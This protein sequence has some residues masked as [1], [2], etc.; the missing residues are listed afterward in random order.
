MKIRDIGST[1]QK[2]LPGDRVRDIM[3]LHP[4]CSSP[5]ATIHDIARKMAE[6]N[7]GEIPI[8]EGDRLVGVVT[9]RDIT[10]RAVSAG[11]H[12]DMTP[13]KEV[14]TSRP[15]VI[16]PEETIE[17]A[18]EM[19]EAFQV[20]RLPVVDQN[21][22]LVGIVSMTDISQ[23]LPRRRAGKLLRNI[24]LRRLTLEPHV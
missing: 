10:C 21:A 14:M 20:R 17:I 13:A 11:R 23:R 18:A 24:S 4:T 6:S 12:P 1:L 15:V 7:C 8:C 16:A 22:H 3:T 5:D 2:D 19:M 9:D